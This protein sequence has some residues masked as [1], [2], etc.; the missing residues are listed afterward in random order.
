MIPYSLD[1]PP[2]PASGA[3]LLPE[4]ISMDSELAL[5]PGAAGCAWKPFN[6]SDLLVASFRVGAASAGHAAAPPRGAALDACAG[7]LHGMHTGALHDAAA[8]LLVPMALGG[9]L[10]LAAAWYAARVLPPADLALQGGVFVDATIAERPAPEPVAEAAV[11]EGV[12]RRGFWSTLFG[13]RADESRAP[14]PT[15]RGALVEMRGIS[16]SLGGCRRG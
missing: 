14:E 11:E 7:A 4:L 3:T 12:E 9:L 10:S 1:S 8:A 5:W 15:S 2:S 16:G 6:A 13:E